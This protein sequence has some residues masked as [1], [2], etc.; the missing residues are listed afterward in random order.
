MA[1]AREICGEFT[2]YFTETQRNNIAAQLAER[3]SEIALIRAEMDAMNKSLPQTLHADQPFDRKPE[4]RV[5]THEN[6]GELERLLDVNLENKEA[7]KLRVE[8][9]NEQ[10]V[11]RF[12]TLSRKEKN[13]KR[14]SRF[15]RMK[16]RNRNGAPERACSNS[17]SSS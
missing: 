6:Q 8:R 11:E 1:Q 9:L 4:L 14:N 12:D 7:T 16:C 15:K 13:R 5:E 10:I 2:Y 17:S 3:D